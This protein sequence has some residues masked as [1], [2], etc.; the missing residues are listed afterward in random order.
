MWWKRVYSRYH[1][2]NVGVCIYFHSNDCYHI[3]YHG[4]INTKEIFEACYCKF[5]TLVALFSTLSNYS[6]GIGTGQHIIKIF[7]V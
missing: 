5:F 2:N 1:G 6:C 3:R 4:N 7:N